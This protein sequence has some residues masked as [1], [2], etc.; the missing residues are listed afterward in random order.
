MCHLKSP[1]IDC[2]LFIANA[3]PPSTRPGIA[4]WRGASE[5]T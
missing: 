4:D 3:M 5:L 1:C 2:Q